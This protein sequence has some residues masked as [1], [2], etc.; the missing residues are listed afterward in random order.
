MNLLGN[1]AFFIFGGVIIF[2]GYILGGLLLCL[3]IIGIPSGIQCFKLAGG[4]LAP[5][6]Q[7]FFVNAFTTS[8]LA[9][10]TL[11]FSAQSASILYSSTCSRISSIISF[12]LPSRMPK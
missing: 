5:F 9:S 2:L 8:G 1:I 12:H 7:T 10:A 3:T 4:V 6:G 11:F